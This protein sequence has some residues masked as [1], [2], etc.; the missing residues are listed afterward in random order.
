MKNRNS[1]K[2]VELMSCVVTL[3]IPMISSGIVRADTTNAQSSSSSQNIIKLTFNPND[4]LTEQALNKVHQGTIK[5]V[6]LIM[7]QNGNE[8]NM[9]M[10]KQP[11]GSY[12][13]TVKENQKDIKYQFKV[14]YQDG[15]SVTIND[16]HSENSYNDQYS[17]VGNKA[18]S[19]KANITITTPDGIV[20][21]INGQY[22]SSSGKDKS[23]S[24]SV[25]SNSKVE[26]PQL[27]ENKESSS[28]KDSKIS[29]SSAIV[30]SK[31][32]ETE[33]NSE[34]SSHISNTSKTSSSEDNKKTLSTSSEKQTNNQ[35]AVVADSQK[36]SGLNNLGKNDNQVPDVV[37]SPN[38]KKEN[39]NQGNNNQPSKTQAAVT[40]K[41]SSQ[42]QNQSTHALSS[43]SIVGNDNEQSMPQTGEMIIR[44][45]SILGGMVLMGVGGYYGYQLYKK[46][47]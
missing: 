4:S 12:T 2:F 38:T 33:Q 32:S 14:D 1:F 47:K 10:T 45:L 36:T 41:E 43:S 27:N 16:P 3:G 21:D 23:V 31:S 5:N 40:N 28:K 17:V 6:S 42:K 25:V 19:S 37:T 46:N 44:G 18:A 26:S 30:N 11:D 8:S 29:S 22:N 24:V 39:N 34:V 35:A 20:I 9:P 13:T 7:I 15:Q